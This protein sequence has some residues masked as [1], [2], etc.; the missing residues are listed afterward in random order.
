MPFRPRQIH[1]N[2]TSLVQG[3]EAPSVNNKGST[4]RALL[5]FMAVVVNVL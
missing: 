1:I 2:W 5:V 3:L 4:W